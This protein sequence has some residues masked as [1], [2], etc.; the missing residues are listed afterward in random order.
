MA[1]RLSRVSL[2]RKVQ[3]PR[4]LHVL[5]ARISPLSL[6]PLDGEEKPKKRRIRK[7]KATSELSLLSRE[8]SLALLKRIDKSVNWPKRESKHV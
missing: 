6:Q 7:G 2:V 5:L 1:N 4:V 3:R 8:K